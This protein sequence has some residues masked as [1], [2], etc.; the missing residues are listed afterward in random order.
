MIKARF[1]ESIAFYWTNCSFWQNQ[2]SFRA[3]K[4]F[5]F[6]QLWKGV[7]GTQI[8]GTPFRSARRSQAK[9]WKL[10]LHREYPWGAKCFFWG[11]Y[12]WALPKEVLSLDY[13][14][15]ENRPSFAVTETEVELLRNDANLSPVAALEMSQNCSCKSS[16]VCCKRNRTVMFSKISSKRVCLI[17]S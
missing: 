3:N 7:I 14:P 5:R 4:T 10:L 9:T 12:T 17:A 2:L 11:G 8:T 16:W 1:V 6:V 15:S 13:Q